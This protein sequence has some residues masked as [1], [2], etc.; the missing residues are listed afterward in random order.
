M[1]HI[2]SGRPSSGDAIV[3]SALWA[4][5]GDVLGWITELAREGG[6]QAR[7]GQSF[8]DRPMDWK[9]LIGGRAGVRI[10]LPAGTYSDDTQ[11]RLAVCRSI[12]G[13]GA[14][15][16]E[17]FACI[18]LPAFQNYALGAGRG[19]KA[20]AANLSRRG[21]NW[22]SNFFEKPTSYVA[23]GGNGA[24]M[25]VQPHVWAMRDGGLDAMTTA[26][27]R[28]AIVTHGHP[29]GFAGAVFHAQTLAVS[30]STG[31]V[32]EPSD[33][34]D[35]VK[36]IRS[37]ADRVEDDRQLSAFWK[38]AWEDQAN[39]K[40]SVAAARFCEEAMADVDLVA[41]IVGRDGAKKYPEILN[42]LGCYDDKYRGSGWKTAL[43]AAALAGLHK[44]N[45]AAALI[46]AANEVGS[47][48]DTIATMAGAILG[49]VAPVDPDWAIQ[50]RDYI[51][52]E[53]RR[54][55]RIGAGEICDSFS[56]PDVAR[57]QAP[58]AQVNFVGKFG[59]RLAL[60]GLGVLEPV[61]DE[62]ASGDT[63]WQWM[64][65]PFGQTVL[66]KRRA[67]VRTKISPSDLPGERRPVKSVELPRPS[68]AT[69]EPSLPFAHMPGTSIGTRRQGQSLPIRNEEPRASDVR[70]MN[71]DELTDKIIASK[72]DDKMIGAYLNILIDKGCAIEIIASFAAII[73]KAKIA[74]RKRFAG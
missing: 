1:T 37:L 38:P 4:A 32:P 39:I 23:A 67:Q 49:A 60:A 56:Y 35:I 61:S 24:A 59:D 74:R 8:V 41:S 9:R 36:N 20:A 30:L 22:F 26:V 14:F 17:A 52:R 42:I 25:R 16:A 68:S 19:T 43:A 27:L 40:L 15:D 31:R 12:R 64:K 6:V 34:R 11:L 70:T 5:A 72:F 28:D 48:T 62:A 69:L 73:A 57:W 65:L 54:L 45:P 58:S 63:I 3:R 50:D 46:E 29:H 53:A 33:W 18:E 21:V 66:A 13:D 10:L 47:D 2:A 7:T 55:S 44:D 71:L 51:V